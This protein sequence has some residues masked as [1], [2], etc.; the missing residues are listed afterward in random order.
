MKCIGRTGKSSFL[1]RCQNPSPRKLW[2]F[3][4]SHF[5]QALVGLVGLLGLADLC[6]W[7][8]RD[9]FSSKPPGPEVKVLFSTVYSTDHQPHS[10]FELTP[11]GR[12]LVFVQL[13]RLTQ[14][15]NRLVF[16]VAIVRPINVGSRS[17]PDL[18]LATL[19]DKLLWH[20][21]LGRLERF[22]TPI[23]GNHDFHFDVRTVDDRWLSSRDL[24]RL[25][26]K[27]AAPYPLAFLLEM[28]ASETFG[29]A[30]LDAAGAMDIILG[31]P[32]WAGLRHVIDIRSL[33]SASAAEFMTASHTL[34]ASLRKKGYPDVPVV[35]AVTRGDGS[36]SVPGGPTIIQ[37]TFD[38]FLEPS[39]RMLSSL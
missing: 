9:L 25:D 10:D 32:D 37:A 1:K 23:L 33:P 3:C 34:A 31:G 24:P 18:Q 22:I 36:V 15:V 8:I 11:G 38:T 29:E 4:Q 30:H 5:W 35:F 12:T 2:P 7:K 39:G 27:T 28:N 13:P 17:M 19:F 21:S 26:P 20:P 16:G 14:P 6:G